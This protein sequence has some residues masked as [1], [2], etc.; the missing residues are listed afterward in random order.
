M[1]KK[2]IEDMKNKNLNRHARKVELSK[3]SYNLYGHKIAPNKDIWIELKGLKGKEE[4][5]VFI[6]IHFERPG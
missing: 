1:M 6:Q 4:N 3:L 5:G 2:I